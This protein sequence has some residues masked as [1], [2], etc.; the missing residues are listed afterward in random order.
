MDERRFAHIDESFGF[1]RLIGPQAGALDFVLQGINDTPLTNLLLQTRLGHHLLPFSRLNVA[2]DASYDASGFIDA[3]LAAIDDSRP[4]FL[5]VHFES[6]HFPFRTRHGHKVFDDDNRFLA[7]HK[8]ALTA[9]DAQIG[10]MLEGLRQVRRLDDALL[11]VLSD[12]GEGFGDVEA[13]SSRDG[14]PIEIASYGH[15]VSLTSEHQ[16]RVVLGLVRFINGRPAGLQ[17]LR[18]DQVSLADVRPVIERFADGGEPTLVAASPCMSVETG[19]RFRAASDYK[20]FDPAKLAAEAAS[21][22]EIDSLGRMHLREDQLLSA[23]EAK[24][25]GWRCHDRL[26]WYSSIEGRYFSHQIIDDG[27]RLVEIQPHT[28]DIER[29]DAYRIQL[30]N[31]VS[32]NELRRNYKTLIT[33]EY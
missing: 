7:Q 28:E 17:R 30:R 12:H 1:D 4:L 13:R 8:A 14:E 18:D 29:I 6:A 23:V 10:R 33:Q 26:T 20:G 25:V 9:V 2:A 19:I 15:G 31:V 32:K 24:D 3:M 5:A 27:E 11:I 16:N 22:Y 21:Y